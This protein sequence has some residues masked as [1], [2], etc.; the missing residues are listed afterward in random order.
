MSPNLLRVLLIEDNPEQAFLLQEQLRLAAR[1]PFVVTHV[2]RI[3]DAERLLWSEPIDVIMSDLNLP[4][5]R[6]L[7]T[8]RRLNECAPDIP[9]L[10]LTALDDEVIA[11]EAL[12]EGAQDYLVKGDLDGAGLARA[13]VA[14]VERSELTRNLREAYAR[15]AAVFDT[16]PALVAFVDASGHVMTVNQRWTDFRAIVD[17]D[18]GTPLPTTACVPVLPEETT[19][20]EAFGQ[21]IREIARGVNQ[22]VAGEVQAWECDYEV[23]LEN[24]PP[25]W[26]RLM[27]RAMDVTSSQRGAVVMH[28]DVTEN[29]QQAEALRLS[30]ERFREMLRHV[31]GVFL[32]YDIARKCILFVSAHFESVFGQPADRLHSDPDA[33]LA[34]VHGDDQQTTRRVWERLKSGRPNR[35]E[36][37]I[38]RADGL[39]RH[40]QMYGQ[41]VREADG[42]MPRVVLFVEDITPTR[43]LEQELLRAQK[44]EAV[45]KLAGG[46]AHDFNNFLAILNNQT[47]LLGMASDGATRDKIIQEIQ[48]TCQRAVGLTKQLSTFGRKQPLRRLPI[49]LKTLLHKST[50]VLMRLLGD[51]IRLEV[52]VHPLVGSVDGDP[53]QLNQVL[54][55]LALQA[56]DTMPDGGVLSIHA[57]PHVGSEP[58][59]HQMENGE[60]KRCIRLTFRDTGQGLDPAAAERIFDPF[61]SKREGGGVSG[62]GMAT[63]Y[64]IVQQ[65]Q[66]RIGV[67]STP[68]QG[69]T[70]R[71]DLPESSAQ[72]TQTG[73]AVR[74]AEPRP[75]TESILIVEDEDV[76]RR[77][78]GE[79]LSQCGYQTHLA[80]SLAEAKKIFGLLTAPPHLL[81]ADVIMPDGTSPD[82]YRELVAQYQPLLVLYISGYPD[83]VFHRYGLS[84]QDIPLIEKPFPPELLISR[85]RAIL[86]QTP[87]DV[88]SNLSR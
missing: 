6:G 2:Q 86:D 14:A 69:T 28:I 88:I 32:T 74:K 55:N 21:T 4:D 41:A 44:L 38:H 31:P 46:I 8:C 42:S 81:L 29:V 26:F 19:D 30:D 68:G 15:Q 60:E 18:R 79:T 72:P 82:L 33:W 27:S 16:L 7:E 75:C 78:M 49:D 62:L 63:V 54:M 56:R 80:S 10:A 57:D 34:H 51:N 59:P 48:D 77:W 39:T 45:G 67:E 5:S 52:A 24:R 73:E 35:V 61:F 71:I 70:F 20:P 43:V 76:L 40:L 17:P 66:G 87:S 53:D 65:H 58:W 12:Q 85:V 84:P 22:V 37:R 25:Q 83:D 13:L 1:R 11:L 64:T 50:A 3:G 23:R 9:L 36:F 47:Q